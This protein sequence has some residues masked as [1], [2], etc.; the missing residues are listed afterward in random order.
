MELTALGYDLS[1]IHQQHASRQL[2]EDSEPPSDL[3][4]KWAATTPE[5]WASHFGPVAPTLS[6]STLRAGAQV[7][8]T[9]AQRQV[10]MDAYGMLPTKVVT[11]TNLEFFPASRAVKRITL[12]SMDH[13]PANQRRVLNAVTITRFGVFMQRVADV[14]AARRTCDELAAE[15]RPRKTR[16][17]EEILE[18]YL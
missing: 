11:I 10:L 17:M 7:T 3:D 18:D 9:S 14:E 12:S 15:R 8:L 13:I 2:R 4:L 1:A 16:R 6:T 5:S